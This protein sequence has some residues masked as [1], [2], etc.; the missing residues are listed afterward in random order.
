MFHK[1]KMTAYATLLLI[2]VLVLPYAGIVAEVSAVNYNCSGS[3]KEVRDCLKAVISERDKTIE[4]QQAAVDKAEADKVELQA[5]VDKVEAELQAATTDADLEARLDAA[6]RL[7]SHTQG[8]R[9]RIEKAKATKIANM[10]CSWSGKTREECVVWHETN[11]NIDAPMIVCERP[12]QGEGAFICRSQSEF[13]KYVQKY[14]DG[15]YDT[16]Q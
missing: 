10:K 3:K 12:E 2:T 8:S 15:C 6:L 7:D 16:S 13:D 11:N 4:E 9:D 5:A 1:F 14:G